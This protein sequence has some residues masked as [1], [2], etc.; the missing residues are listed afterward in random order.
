[1]D[2]ERVVGEASEMARLLK[3]LPYGPYNY[4]VYGIRV[5]KIV[6]GF[7]R[8]YIFVHVRGRTFA[9]LFWPPGVHVE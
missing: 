1:M 6:F 7:S 3:Y 2:P 8:K 9:L 5:G 4:T